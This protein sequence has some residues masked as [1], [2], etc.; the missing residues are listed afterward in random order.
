MK[1]FY[2]Q[3]NV[4]KVKYLLNFHDGERKHRDGSD[5]YD[6]RFFKNKKLFEKAQKELILQG[7]SRR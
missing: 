1:K 7:Y 5:F 2:V 6:A 4:G 3:Y